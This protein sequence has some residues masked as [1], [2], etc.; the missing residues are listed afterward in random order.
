MPSNIN[1]DGSVTRQHQGNV[2]DT[3]PRSAQNSDFV[4]Q[5]QAQTAMPEESAGMAYQSP[6]S[7]PPPPIRQVQKHYKGD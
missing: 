4:H 2:G 6:V 7:T 3:H 1:I 5:D